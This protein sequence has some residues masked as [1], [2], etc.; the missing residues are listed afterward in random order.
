MRGDGI[1]V[2]G[3]RMGLLLSKLKRIFRN[4]P[5]PVEPTGKWGRV[6]THGDIAPDQTGEVCVNL[7][8]GT[9]YF[10]ARAADENA[11]IRAGEEVVVVSYEPPRTVIVARATD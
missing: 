9:E 11:V 4:S 8:G 5:N 1:W 7:G 6:T 10:Y 3:S 2:N